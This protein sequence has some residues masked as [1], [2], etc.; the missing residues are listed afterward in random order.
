[1]TGRED[2]FRIPRRVPFHTS[3]ERVDISKSSQKDKYIENL[4]FCVPPICI[5]SI[6]KLQ[7]AICI[8]SLSLKKEEHIAKR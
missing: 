7:V 8:I 6:A 4:L 5:S 1:M 2:Q 3:T